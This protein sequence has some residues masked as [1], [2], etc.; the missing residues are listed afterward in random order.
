MKILLLSFLVGIV[1]SVT[2]FAEPNS[3]LML[4]YQQPAKSAMNEALPIGNGRLGGMVFGGVDRE[5]IQFN[6]DSL[7]T[8]DDNPSGNDNTMGAYQ[9][10]GD[11]FLSFDDGLDA[12]VQNY[13]RQL[14]LATATAH[15]EFTRNGVR[16]VR[17]AFASHP[18][19][20]IVVRWS[21]DKPGAITGHVEL[22]GAHGEQTAVDG[23]MLSFHGAR[24]ATE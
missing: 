3:G 12:P 10:F 18:A 15:T 22:K 21:A 14:D 23:K 16:Y 6:E 5:R 4:W 11:L 17:E 1:G 19:Q 24:S 20:V 13:R 7:W 9:A 2:V 8:G